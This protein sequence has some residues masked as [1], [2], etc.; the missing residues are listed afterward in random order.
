MH[1]NNHTHQFMTAEI[2]D[3]VKVLI[4]DLGGVIINVDMER[5]FREVEKLGVDVRQLVKTA[6][7]NASSG[8][9]A[10]VC[11]GLSVGGVMEQYQLG[12]VSTDLFVEGVRRMCKPGVSRQQIV[13]AWNACLLDIPEHR[14]DTIRSLR[15][16]YKVYLLSNTND[17]HWRNIVER[18]FS[19]EGHTT[20]CFFDRVFVSHEM[21]LAKPDKRIFRKVL[22]EIGAPADEC[23]FFD[24]SSLNIAAAESVG[25]KTKL[26]REFT[27]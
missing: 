2:D 21:H 23:M 26:V 8:T 10:V 13:D 27:I 7:E 3:K 14:L 19:A 16:K 18:Y 15:R 12:T 17:L 6:G 25:M 11:E 24:D 1:G 4:F 22:E 5:S 20:D 9:G